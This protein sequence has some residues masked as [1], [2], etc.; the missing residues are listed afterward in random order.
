[1]NRLGQHPFPVTARFEKS[2]VLSYAIDRDLLS[3]TIPPC[4]E[5]DLHESRHAFVALA[6]V[7]TR[8]LRPSG[9]P[10]FLGKNFTLIGYR[11][12]VRYRG[13][14]GR[15]LRGLYILGSETD[16][17]IMRLLGGFFTT[18]RYDTAAIEWHSTAETESIR[19]STGLR[20][21]ARR[22]DESAPLPTTSP[23][24]DWRQARLFSGP[25]PFTFS[26]NQA[27]R[28]VVIVEGVR[29]QWKPRPMGILEEEVPFFSRLDPGPMR[30][31]NAFLVE[32]VD[33]TWRRGRVEV[34]KE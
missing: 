11:V 14:D 25:L 4:L 18:Y 2:L 1:M 10:K 29:S 34:W 22:S 6:L 33:Y 24:T 30:L 16:R 13:A 7:Q 28:E 23:F 20:I 3:L 8:E 26:W 17:A 32:N 9:F 27:R 21:E 15:R 12:F 31:A 5:L 19:S